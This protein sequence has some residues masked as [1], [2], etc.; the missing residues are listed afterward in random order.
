MQL[1][2]LKKILFFLTLLLSFAACTPTTSAPEPLDGALVGATLECI[3]ECVLTA[4]SITVAYWLYQGEP[5]ANCVD[6]GDSFSKC[7]FIYGDAAS[8]STLAIQSPVVVVDWHSLGQN[9]R[10]AIIE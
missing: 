1:S 6:A 8:S 5:V 2:N 9:Y 3:D 10:L 4:P 7:T